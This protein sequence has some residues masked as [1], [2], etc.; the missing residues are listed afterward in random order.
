MNKHSPRTSLFLIELVLSIFFFIVA[1]AVCMQLFVNTYL[2]NQQTMEINQAL[3]W[4]Q[5][6]AEPF[7][8]NDGDYSIIKTL[9]SDIDCITEFSLEPDSSLLLCFDKNWNSIHSFEDSKYIIFSTF[10][11]DETFFYQD[12]YIAKSQACL[13]SI[14]SIHEMTEKLCNDD[15]HIYQLT[16][17]KVNSKDT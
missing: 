5:N 14:I 4:S 8:G 2:L 12:I 17:K 15:Y 10:S 13:D 11:N 7:L 9:F 6:L 16:L 1:T 3:L